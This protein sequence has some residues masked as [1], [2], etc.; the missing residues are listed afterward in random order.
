MLGTMNDITERRKAQDL[1]LRVGRS[2]GAHTGQSFLRSLVTHLAQALDVDYAFVG[3]L[4]RNLPGRVKTV[5]VLANGQVVDNFEYDLVHTPCENVMNGAAC[6]YPSHVQKAFPLDDLLREM[7]VDGYVGTPLLDSTGATKGLMVVLS[8]K[9]ILNVDLAESVLQIFA[10]RAAAELERLEAEAQIRGLNAGLEQRVKERT[11]QLEYANRELESFSYSVSHDLSAPLRNIS[12]FVQLLQK[13]V[14][15][16][17]DDKSER[18]LE[19]ISDESRRMGTLI[20]SLLDF[21]KLSRTELQKTAVD[22]N[23]LVAEVRQ[24]FLFEIQDRSIEWRIEPL[25]QVLGD[26]NLL[27]Q[28]LS[29]FLSNAIKYTRTRPR[30]E[31]TVGC[32]RSSSNEVVVF[33]RDNGVGFNMKHA[34]KLFGV[35][36]RLHSVKEF[37]GTGIGL[38]NAQ[39]IIHRHRGRVWAE[40]EEDHGATF[41]FTLPR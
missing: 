36:Q 14:N 18:Y 1:I 6:S 31:I 33:V 23:R 25:P 27:K 24:Q 2:I 26:W 15:G 37:E 3:E 29:N 20:E 39:R 5:A 30:A 22:L 12:G 38:A 34:S 40:A 28:V 7:K 11:A 8:S 21:S 17:L 13:R 32:L 35:F 41:F 4:K 16:S 9:P 10:A 19:T